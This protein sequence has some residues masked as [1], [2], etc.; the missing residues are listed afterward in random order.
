MNDDFFIVKVDNKK[1]KVT[2]ETVLLKVE[3]ERL[4][5]IFYSKLKQD[6]LYNIIIFFRKFDALNLSLQTR[7]FVLDICS[8]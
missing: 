2:Y 1:Y 7:L 3:N 4:L 5:S 8:F 6:I